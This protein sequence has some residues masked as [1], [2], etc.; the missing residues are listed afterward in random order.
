MSEQEMLAKA[1][2][3]LSSLQMLEIYC[4]RDDFGAVVGVAYTY[5]K[6]SVEFEKGLRRAFPVW[7]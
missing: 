3:K 5:N 2:A 7:S 1:R 4:L 6:V